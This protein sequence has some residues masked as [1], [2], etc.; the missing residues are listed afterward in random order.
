MPYGEGDTNYMM[1]P[2][3]SCKYWS[4]VK[5]IHLIFNQQQNNPICMYYIRFRNAVLILFYRQGVIVSWALPQ[6]PTI[7]EAHPLKTQQ[8]IT[9]VRQNYKICSSINSIPQILQL[10][11]PRLIL[12]LR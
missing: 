6:V 9:A 12:L 1:K 3:A 8:A 10:N 5:G 4:D 2:M 11:Q 7:G